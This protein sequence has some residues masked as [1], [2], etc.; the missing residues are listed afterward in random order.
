LL[1]QLGY[2]LKDRLTGALLHSCYSQDKDELVIQFDFDDKEFFIQA[3][4]R[5]DLSML[6]IP[7]NFIRAKKNSVNLFTEINNAQVQDVFC[8]EYERCLCLKL[9]SSWSLL[10]KMF[11]NQSN[12]V[13]CKNGKA[14]ALFKHKLTADLN[15]TTGAMNRKF[16]VSRQ[17][18]DELQGD[19]HK[20]LPTLGGTVRKHLI[21]CGYDEMGMNEKWAMIKKVLGT[22]E[23]PNYY[24]Y[25]QES[26]P[27]LSMLE[28]TDYFFHTKHVGEG[29]DEFF[30]QYVRMKQL[31][32]L[33]KMLLRL[34]E[35][36][37]KRAEGVIR[38][39]QNRL[40]QLEKEVGHREIADIIMA[41]MHLIPSGAANVELPDFKTGKPISIK[42]KPDLTPQKNAEQY[43]RKSKNQRKEVEVLRQNLSRSQLQLSMT[44]EH[45]V[46]LNQCKDLKLIRNYAKDHKLNPAKQT[47]DPWSLFKEFK[48]QNFVIL[49]GKNATNNDLLTQKFAHKEDLW[50]HAKDVKGSHVI[51]KH[52]PG[53]PFPST[54]IESA[55]QLAAYYSKR[56][57]DSLCP[58][59]YTPKKY[60]RKSKGASP[61]QVVVEREKVLLVVPKAGS[62]GNRD[63]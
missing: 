31:I 42:L 60:V 33:Q 28:P 56:K 19:F 21:K 5:P 45:I 2:R 53:R 25:H 63:L 15:V 18:F 49:I 43:Y 20:M 23:K 51:I 8:F 1:R 44:E 36:R 32:S 61:G 47:K 13:L 10:F 26:G 57:N 24:L 52:L 39:S 14:Y 6:R 46:F 11:G 37:K 16:K 27:V 35:R 54:V 38:K 3:V 30:H 58:V 22:L 48:F 55:A 62:F 29:L 41:N 9:E 12:V 34:L 59:I 7:R 50:L 40:T 17:R 4:M